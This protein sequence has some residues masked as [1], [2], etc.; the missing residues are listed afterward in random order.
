[1]SQKPTGRPARD[2]FRKLE[3]SRNQHKFRTHNG[4]YRRDLSTD[5]DKSIEILKMEP[6]WH[7]LAMPWPCP[8]MP[9]PCHGRLA[10][11]QAGRLA[12]HGGAAGGRTPAPRVNSIRPSK[13]PKGEA[14]DPRVQPLSLSFSLFLS[15]FLS[16]TGR[17]AKPASEGRRPEPGE[18]RRPEQAGGL[19]VLEKQ[20]Y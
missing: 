18:G 19:F 14:P 16:L 15:L 6:G 20:K 12:C 11:W 5:M 8:D 3:I 1:M 17:P 13:S 9:W 7:A 2:I 4:R 10:G